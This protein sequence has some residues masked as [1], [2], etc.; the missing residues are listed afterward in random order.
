M[1]ISHMNQHDRESRRHEVE[2]YEEQSVPVSIS[3]IAFFS[4]IGNSTI[5]ELNRRSRKHELDIG[6][7]LIPAGARVDRIY[8]TL[9]GELRSYFYSRLGRVVSLPQAHQNGF[10]EGTALTGPT[11]LPYTIEAITP[12]TVVSVDA[13]G[14]FSCA[15]RNRI[16]MQRLFDALIDARKVYIEQII[17]L[18]TMSVKARIYSELI[19]LCRDKQDRDGSATILPPPTHADLASRVGTQREAVSRELSNLQSLGVVKRRGGALFVPSV[20][21]LATLQFEAEA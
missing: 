5:H 13:N 12:S 11:S 3:E 17:E 14:L 21:K 20:S 1:A 15:E 7:I 18:S 16:L 2:K 4:G 19:R 10:L 8:F 6:D 9:R